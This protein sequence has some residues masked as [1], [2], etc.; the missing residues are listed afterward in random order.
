MI[1]ALVLILIASICR[2]GDEDVKVALNIRAHSEEQTCDNLPEITGCADILTTHSGCGDVDVFTVFFDFEGCRH[3]E[4]GLDWPA[5]WGSAL[6][7][8]CADLAINTITMP[9][10][11]ISVAWSTCQPGPTIVS[12]WTWLVAGSSGMIDPIY[13][14]GA[15][16]VPPFLGITDC[17]FVERGVICIF[18]GG[19][20][21]YCGDDPCGPSATEA[22]TWGAIKGMFK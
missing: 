16:S 17:D 12:A 21:G 3:T 5:E 11:W 13:R 20:C 8:H 9:G 10:D 19:I 14:P 7:T 18:S 6:T 15:E 22:G 1:G 2:A 4:W